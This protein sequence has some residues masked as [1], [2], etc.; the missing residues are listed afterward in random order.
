MN[1][2]LDMTNLYYLIETGEEASEE[3]DGEDE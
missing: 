1:V 3:G 2:C